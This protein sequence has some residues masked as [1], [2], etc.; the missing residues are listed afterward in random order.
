MTPAEERALLDATAAD[1]DDEVRASYERLV[2]LIRAGVAPRDAVQQVMESFKGPMADTLAGALSAVMA[3]SVGAEAVLAM[4]VGGIQLS[5]RLYAATTAYGEAV[6][7]IVRAH[8]AGFADARALALQLFE[9]YGFRDAAA[10]PLQ[11]WPG[12]SALPR[13]LREALLDD[14]GIAGE[15]ARA[16]ARIQADGLT[17]PALRAAYSELLAALDG[18]EAGAGEALLARGRR[19][20][21]FERM[22]YFANRI[23]Q[24]EIHRAYMAREVLQQRDD[25]EIEYV[26]V[27]MN[28]SHP[29]PDICDYYSGLDKYGLGRGVYP[30]GSA[31]VP[32][33]HPHC[34]CV[35]SPR[36]DLTGRRAR[37]RDGAEQGYFHGLGLQEG[38]RVAGSRDKL[39]QVLRGADPRAVHNSG[40]DP[41]YQVRLAREVVDVH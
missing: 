22:L 12:N 6:A 21:Y 25:A 39:E 19:T 1:L 30:K 20:A 31:P 18:I 34:R 33:F 17:T 37:E 8:V 9:G 27:R 36:L 41:L 40:T 23:A 28:P 7:G 16:L 2:E 5:A 15:M 26:Q 32:P 13:Y 29:A 3:Q 24:T 38:A 11:L 35:L 4:E 14:A 10:E